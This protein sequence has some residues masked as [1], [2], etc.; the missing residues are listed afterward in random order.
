MK[1]IGFTEE[2]V[3]ELCSKYNC[4]FQKVMKWYDGYLLEE[5]QVYNPKAVVEVLTWN[6][7]Q[8]Y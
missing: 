3:K 2:E 7:Y 4:D 8:S 1:Y 5:H 6:K